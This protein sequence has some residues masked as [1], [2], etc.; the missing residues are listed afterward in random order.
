MQ[1]TTSPSHVPYG[2]VS[3]FFFLILLVLTWGF[4]RTYLVFFPSFEGFTPV[5]HFHGAMMIT[6]MAVLIVQ[7]LLI[8]TGKLSIHRLVGRLTFII[9]P[10]VVVSMFLITK[11]SYYKP[12]PPL[13][14]QERLG[15][16]SLQAFDIVQFVVFYCLA[17]VNRRNTYNHMR[18]MIGTGIM[19]I[20]PGLGRA[21]IIYYHMPFSPAVSYALGVELAIAAAFLLSDV[22]RKGSYKANTIIVS[23]MIIHLLFWEFR[24]YQP[25]QGIGEIIASKLF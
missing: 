24:M 10:L 12:V 21:L 22:V 19:M 16:L 14:H 6:W 4:Y 3:F 17:I 25:W 23:L 8:R 7:P 9:A 18:Y 1:L 15:G 5:Q 2:R 11:F 20:G 13:S